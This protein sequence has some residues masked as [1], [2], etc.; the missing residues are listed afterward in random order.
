MRAL[1]ESSVPA[2]A[3]FLAG[4]PLPG[5][6]GAATPTVTPGMPAD[7]ATVAEVEATA[8]Q[9]VA[10]SNEPNLPA[11]AALLTEQGAGNFLSFG[12]LQFQAISSG[13][14]GTPAAGIDPELINIY[15]ASMQLQTPLPPEFRL[16]LYG[17]E[18][19]TQLED[20]RVRAIVLLATGSEEP[21]QSGMLLREED[22]R[23]RIIFGRETSD[24][25]ESTPAP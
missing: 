15:L 16:T 7:A 24:A 22:G 21:R 23:Y 17:I 8:R 20:G 13:A 19:V 2:I 14:T 4:T 1:I 9:F 25:A 12:F 18:S 3:S 6:D 5:T 11:V 10:C